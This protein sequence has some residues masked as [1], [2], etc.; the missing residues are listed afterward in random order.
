M[1][2]KEKRINFAIE[3]KQWTAT[4]WGNILFR[5]ESFLMPK[6]QGPNIYRILNPNSN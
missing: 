4:D 6:R 3:H 5:D 1:E 2:N